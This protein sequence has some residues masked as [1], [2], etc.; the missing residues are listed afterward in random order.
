MKLKQAISL[1]T[2]AEMTG[3]KPVGDPNFKITGINEIHKV[4]SG[5]L[6]F[7]DL[8]KY[9]DVALNSAATT[10]I[11][12]KEVECP[13]GKALL[14]ADD[15]FEAYNSLTKHFCPFEAATQLIS[16]SAE[17]GEGTHLQP[18][19]F[20]GNNVKIGKNCLIHPQ[21]VIYDNAEV[22][23]NVIIHSGT[24]IGADAFYFKTRKTP[25]NYYEKMHS[26]GKVVIEDNVE[27]GAN[28]TI[29]K[30]VSGITRIGRGSK[31][32]NLA[33]I[34]HG[35][36]IGKNCLIG[37]QVG[38]AG[39]TRIHDEVVIWGQVGVNKDID[40]GPK[41]VVLACS[42]VSK[43]LEGGKVYFGAPAEEARKVWREYA[44]VRQLPDL[45]QKLK[46]KK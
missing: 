9:Y 42:A 12:D 15:P 1:Q 40:I 37:S 17:I 18:G 11:I 3:A 31:I 22:G 29:D 13:E 25:D 34:G 35:V 26:C 6:T 30:G 4:E 46:E 2:L 16:P 27:I 21:V 7:V 36:V 10:I 32:D 39:K 45:L 43:S 5:D 8:P 20:V 14:I 23:N 33:Q 38:I 19:V 24:I 41:A 28:C 44:A